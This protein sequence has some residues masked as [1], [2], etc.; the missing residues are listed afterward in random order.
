MRGTERGKI[1]V[2]RGQH[3]DIGGV[4]AE[5]ARDVAIVDSAA[6]VKLQMH[7]RGSPC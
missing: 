1:A 6:G 3:D 7:A 4:L 2:R 5:I